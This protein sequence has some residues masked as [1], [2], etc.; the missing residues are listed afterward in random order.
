MIIITILLPNKWK[1][2]TFHAGCHLA[3]FILFE[4]HEPCFGEYVHQST[5]EFGP[6]PIHPGTGIPVTA[7]SDDGG[8][9]AQF[10]FRQ[11][12]KGISLKLT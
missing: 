6:D 1:S 9:R 12:V 2:P 3:V 4:H 10:P 5:V 7:D 11:A 8:V